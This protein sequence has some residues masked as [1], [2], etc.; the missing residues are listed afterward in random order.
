MW[1]RSRVVMPASACSSSARIVLATTRPASRMMAISR[2]DLR[3]M[4]LSAVGYRCIG[5]AAV[6]VLDA[7]RLIE[8][9][10]AAQ[11]DAV[12]VVVC[13]RSLQ[14]D[15]LRSARNLSPEQAALRIAAQRPV[16]DKLRHATAV[17]TNNTTLDDLKT[18][19]AAAWQATASP[20]GR[21]RA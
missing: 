5:A 9:G 10:L 20:F 7:I 14:V 17:I 21:G 8:S 18:Q 15:R 12:W 3:T 19:I 13:D 4:V 2:E 1:S 16:E 6:V 11:C